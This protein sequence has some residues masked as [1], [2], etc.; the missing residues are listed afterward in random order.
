MGLR[1]FI[2]L[3]DL[4]VFIILVDLSQPRPDDGILEIPFDQ[5]IGDAIVS[6]GLSSSH[7][8]RLFILDI[9]WVYLGSVMVHKEKLTLHAIE[10]LSQI[11][12]CFFHEV[13][14]C[15]SRI[16]VILLE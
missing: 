15:L 8:D 7:N 3:I 16:S 10:S 1:Q 4:T 11:F 2:C 13:S 9:E 12:L 14:Y 6:K 5:C